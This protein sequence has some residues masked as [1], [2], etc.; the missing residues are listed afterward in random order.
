MTATASRNPVSVHRSCP[1]CEASCGLCI[2]VDP[3]ARSVLSI[4]GDEQ[5]P[6]SRGFLCPK[7]TAMR[8][9]YEDPDRLTRPLRRTRG[10]WQEISWDDAFELV[11]SRLHAIRE[12]H[13]VNAVGTY[14]G[15]PIGFSLSGLVYAPMYTQ[16][17]NSERLFSAATMDQL[18]KNLSSR[19]L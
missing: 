11:G 15:N 13:G 14:I 9:L 2:E 18:P 16:A 8:G 17:L 3:A 12:A 6:R 7:A 4:R 1:I 5:D 19:L 10:G